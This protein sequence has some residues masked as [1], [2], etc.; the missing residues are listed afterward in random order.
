MAGPHDIGYKSLFAHPELVRELVKGFTPFCWLGEL[1][2]VAFERVNPAYVSERF[3]ERQDDIVWRVKVGP[4]WLYIY[5]LLEFQ[6]KVDRWM[7]LRLQVYIGLLYQDLVK[8]GEL[9]RDGKLPAVLPVVFYTGRARWTASLEL[10]DM[11]APT[12]DGI[13]DLQASQ[14]YFLVDQ[15][16]LDTSVLARQRSIL[17]L[18][19]QME[20]S[21]TAVVIEESAAL[22]MTWLS[23]DDQTQLRRDV[24]AWL[25]HLLNREFKVQVQ[26][27]VVPEPGGTNMGERKFETWADM[28]E[29]R[30]LQRGLEQGREEA[31]V[32]EAA[33]L[34]RI[35]ENILAKRF[36]VLP[37]G[38]AARLAT[39]STEELQE[40]I[41]R[42]LE[43]DSVEALFGPANR[44]SRPA[45]GP[46]PALLM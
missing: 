45:S 44:Y 16:R 18:L 6:S 14:R 23:E 19:F 12:P 28:Y 41:D 4:Q 35:L 31:R 3:S 40:W 34:R 36:S 32:R 10:A 37:E 20:L 25:D 22:L 2:T 11:I 9:A 5:I 30:G 43:T 13:A 17:S 29:D 42:A 8:R 27:D 1:D 24:H 21:D 15:R 33:T 39:A 7:A 26:G 38:T 46:D